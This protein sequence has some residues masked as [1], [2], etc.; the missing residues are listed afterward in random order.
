MQ[1]P[2]FFKYAA[3]SLHKLQISA[4]NMRGLHGFKIPAFSL[5]KITYILAES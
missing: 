3:L 2:H 1:G 4:Q 5:Q